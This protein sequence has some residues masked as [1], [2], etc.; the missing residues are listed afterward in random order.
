MHC[1]FDRLIGRSRT[2]SAKWQRYGDDVLPLWV[3]DLDFLS[4]EPVIRALQERA[5]HG[6]FGY[7]TEP[8]ELRPVIVERLQRQYGWS[9]PT[10]A[11]I[12][13]SGVVT[14]FN[15]ACQAVT[16]PGD[17]M[18]LQTPVYPPMFRVPANAGLT[19]EEMELTRQEDGRY[20]IDFDL[21]ERTIRDKT[22]VFLL[23]NPHNPIGRVYERAELEQMAEICLRNRMI[24][25]SDEIHCE[26]VYR[27]NPHT[28]IASL[29]PKVANQTITLMAPSKT[30]NIPGLHCS[31]A[32]IENPDL[33]ERFTA[34]RRG[35]VSSVGIMGYV[36]ALAA[37]RDGQS[38]LD[39]LLLYLEAN[40]DFLGEYVDAHLPG[41]RMAK[42]EGTFLAWLDCREAG[43]EGNP[44]R[45][46]LQEA[47]VALNDGAVFGNGGDG[48]VRLNFGCCRSGLSQA[49]GRMRQALTAALDVR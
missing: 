16:E 44:Q 2:D 34:A 19:L 6:V 4:P 22:R 30:F 36:A 42:P 15:L 39:E 43:I 47:K 48:F 24:I 32:I 27:G 14:A 29:G 21:M 7:G 46:F 5:A 13:L 25:C 12:F 28:P 26:L 3:A 37:Y 18:L 10:E 41:V 35:L 11:I 45:F 8:P 20:P 33:R 23:C 49:L 31:M 9:V 38:W 1:E 40:R 17:G